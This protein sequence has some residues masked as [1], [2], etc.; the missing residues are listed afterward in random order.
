MKSRLPILTGAIV[1]TL[2]AARV[3]AAQAPAAA[4][5]FAKDVAPIVF[6]KCAMCHRPGEVAPMS[7]LTYEQVRP[8][9]RAIRSKVISREMPPWGADPEHGTFANDRSLTSREIETITAWVDGGGQRGRDADMPAAPVFAAGWHYGEPE[10]VIEMVQD[11]LVPAEGEMPNLRFYAP[12]P[13]QQDRFVRLVEWR[14]GDRSVVHHGNAAVGDLPPGSR[15]DDTPGKGGELILADGTRENDS[16]QQRRVQGEERAQFAPLLD[17]VPGRYGFPVPSPDVGFRIPA[18]KHV[19]F[20]THYQASG[21]PTLDRSR[22]GLWFSAKQQVQELYRDGI[23]QALQ[24][25]TD[26]IG[27]FQVEGAS[28]TYDP[29]GG[30]RWEAG[31]RPLPAFSDNY[32]V[33]GLTPIVE[34]I[35]LYGFTPHMHLRGKDMK[36]LLTMPDG[37]S[38]TLLNVP[39]YDFNWQIYYELTQPRKI[40]A[41]STISTV[42]HYDNTAT[43]KYNPAPDREVF[44]S[45]QSWDE[46]FLPFIAYTVDREN[47]AA[48]TQKTQPQR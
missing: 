30:V 47:P 41:G 32:T 31:W 20:G 38:E 9:M 43:N 21:K 7:L 34:P 22:I 13:F 1:L 48:T 24:T 4:P 15:I 27:F 19:R 12:V 39:K 23:G 42:A 16:T 14:P 5:T 6:A 18:G 2:M 28:E 40:P 26:Q 36:W 11:Y 35:T 25:S 10:F 33:V 8:W 46:M 29:A 45:E 17:W 44:W 3:A 37:R